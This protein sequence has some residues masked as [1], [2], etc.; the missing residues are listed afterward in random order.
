MS[1]AAVSAGAT[2]RIDRIEKEESMAVS[3]ASD[4]APDSVLLHQDG[5]VCI[6]H[7]IAGKARDLSDRR[8]PSSNLSAAQA[9]LLW[10]PRASVSAL[11]RALPVAR[12]IE[13][14]ARTP[15]LQPIRARAV[16]LASVPAQVI[17]QTDTF[18]SVP[19]G[20]L[21]VRA[22]ADGSGELIAYHRADQPGPKESVYTRV[23]C[24]DARA[25]VQALGS[26]LPVRG[27]VVKRREVFL[28]GRTRVH[29]DEVQNLG[30]FVE[31]ET[32]LDDEESQEDGQQEVHELLHALD[33]PPSAL[34]AEAYIDL[35]S[36]SR[37]AAHEHPGAR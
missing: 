11:A 18:F 19:D 23:A 8:A 20:R 4:D 26:V 9:V 36:D 30:C 35:L 32:M 16:S 15:N 14:K 6:V 37:G 31:I 17:E 7:E 21:K 12:N 28:V 5:G 27:K 33:I 29:L 2:E 22:F 3:V 13:I 24:A 25:V 34:V 1:A 10:M